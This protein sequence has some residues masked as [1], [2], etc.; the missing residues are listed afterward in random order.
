[1]LTSRSLFLSNLIW[2]KKNQEIAITSY[3]TLSIGTKCKIY[4]IITRRDI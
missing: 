3:L 1:M 2:I 4:K